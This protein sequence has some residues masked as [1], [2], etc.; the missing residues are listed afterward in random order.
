VVL[1]IVK[2]DCLARHVAFI[3]NLMESGVELVAVDMPQA[4]RLTRHILTVVAWRW[5]VG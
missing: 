5:T 1:V 2:L 4:N 3:A